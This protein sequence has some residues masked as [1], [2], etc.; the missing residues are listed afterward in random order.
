MSDALLAC[1]PGALLQGRDKAL[2]GAAGRR[3]QEA[4]A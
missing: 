4:I 2:L 3:R 1:L